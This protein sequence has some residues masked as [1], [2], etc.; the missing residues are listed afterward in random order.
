[1]ATKL[2][3]CIVS[4]QAGGAT[5]VNSQVF[6]IIHHFSGEIENQLYRNFGRLSF[7]TL[8]HHMLSKRPSMLLLK[9]LVASVAVSKLVGIIHIS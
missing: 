6:N 1:M 9:N 8:L 3:R 5:Q 7:I 2:C 4:D